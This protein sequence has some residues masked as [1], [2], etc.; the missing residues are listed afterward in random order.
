MEK[1]KHIILLFTD[2]ENQSTSPG[3]V[4]INIVHDD[5]DSSDDALFS[6]G[7]FFRALT[8]MSV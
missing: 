5:E 1:T 8:D 2:V 3:S 7:S 6:F 4:I